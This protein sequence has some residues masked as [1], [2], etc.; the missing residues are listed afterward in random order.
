MTFCLGV[1][2]HEGIVGIADSRLTS[3]KEIISAKKMNLFHLDQG[4]F[5]IMTSGLRSVRD[6][7]LTYFD[8]TLRNRGEPIDRLFK[9]VNIF[10][11]QIRQVSKEDKESLEGS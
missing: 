5:F 9:A 7:A 6:K 8:E 3:G 2:V 4:A 1:T 10:S 11:N